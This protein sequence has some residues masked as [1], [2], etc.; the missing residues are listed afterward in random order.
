[1]IGG[2]LGIF[3]ED[4]PKSPVR[5]QLQHQSSLLFLRDA[6]R[7]LYLFEGEAG[8]PFCYIDEPQTAREA[9]CALPILIPRAVDKW[10]VIRPLVVL[11]MELAAAFLCGARSNLLSTATE[12]PSRPAIKL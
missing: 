9:G 12:P 4:D 6:D 10:P 2:G 11:W 7:R 5:L 3:V 1:M 8:I